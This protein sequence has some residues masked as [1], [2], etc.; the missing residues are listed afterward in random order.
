MLHDTLTSNAVTLAGKVRTLAF[1]LERVR[2]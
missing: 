1:D 2:S